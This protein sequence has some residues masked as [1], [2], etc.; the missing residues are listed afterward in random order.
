V[1]DVQ[2]PPEQIGWKP[3]G[4]HLQSAVELH[5]P[6]HSDCCVAAAVVFWV[7]LVVVPPEV[8]AG[9]QRTSLELLQYPEPELQVPPTD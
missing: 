4:D 5:E 7:E 9:Q 6:P 2:I 3:I 1:G 8:V